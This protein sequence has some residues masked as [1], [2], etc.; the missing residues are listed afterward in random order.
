MLTG[1][2][3]YELVVCWGYGAVVCMNAGRSL[4]PG[5]APLA[6]ERPTRRSKTAIFLTN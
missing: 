5:K 3:C 1:S 6:S 4:D 2:F